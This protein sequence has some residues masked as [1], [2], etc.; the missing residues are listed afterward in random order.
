L[1][2]QKIVGGVQELYWCAKEDIVGRV[3][4]LTTETYA[5]IKE[6]SKLKKFYSFKSLRDELGM[7]VLI[8]G[9]EQDRELIERIKGELPWLITTLHHFNL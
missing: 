8:C 1:G 7:T 4:D 2:V 5:S 9:Q 3:E 6:P